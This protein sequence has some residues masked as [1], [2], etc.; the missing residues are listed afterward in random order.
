MIG[1][2]R[3]L[4]MS[5]AAMAAGLIDGIPPA[6]ARYGCSPWQPFNR[7][8]I[9][10]CSAGIRIGGFTAQQECAQWCWAACIQAAFD[11]AGYEVPQEAIVEKLFGSRFV[12]QPAIGPQ[13]AGAITGRWTDRRGRRFRARAYVLADLM[14]G[15]VNPSALSQASRFLADD[16]PLI[17][18]ALGHATLMTSMTWVEDNFGQYQL[19]EIIVRDPWPGSPNRRHLSAK[20]YY[21]SMFLAAVVAG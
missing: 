7:G 11:L 20:E 17:N 1:R 13:I 8:M 3:L 2:R 10:Q 4:A 21:G 18:G 5:T 15:I 6:I 16:V 12:C 9:R 14:F 19:Q